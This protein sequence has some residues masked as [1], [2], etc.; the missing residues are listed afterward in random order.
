MSR[1]TLLALG[2]SL[3][4]AGAVSFAQGP[5]GLVSF[6]EIDPSTGAGR[7]GA[8]RGRGPFVEVM[9][10]TNWSAY[11]ACKAG[12]AGACG[13]N[14]HEWSVPFIPQVSSDRLE[15]RL[16]RLYNEYNAYVTWRMNSSLNSFPDPG[17]PG[18]SYALNCVAGQAGLVVDRLVDVWNKNPLGRIA[19]AR[20]CD[21]LL[22]SVVPAW[23]KGPCA[24]LQANIFWPEVRRRYDA[25]LKHA[26][27]VYRLNYWRAVNEAI[28]TYMPGALDWDG[29]Y[30]LGAVAAGTTGGS[31][32]QPVYAPLPNTAQYQQLAQRA[33][34]KHPLGYNY[35]MN[36]YAGTGAAP[37]AVRQTPYN[38]LTATPAGIP[39]LEELKRGLPTREDIF[40]TVWKW[41]RDPRPKGSRG[42][43]TLREMQNV[44]HVTFLRVFARNDLE[45]SPRKVALQVRCVT[46]LG[47]SVTREVVISNGTSGRWPLRFEETR[48]HTD[49]MSVPEGY[50]IPNVRNTPRARP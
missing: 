43:G 32:I 40:Q 12:N 45:F 5:V 41:A 49:W 50:V 6:I 44:G 8:G 33:Q 11:R 39:A 38:D 13:G 4:I 3:L 7:E 37:S 25:V 36:R 1:K 10:I 47:Q 31:T 14:N 15:E 46:L 48:A 24:T 35:I 20:F 26:R 21:N 28:S 27:L 17:R 22:P 19:S 23:I 18:Y 29:A 16:S 30:D 42:T 2:A 34:Q 9:H